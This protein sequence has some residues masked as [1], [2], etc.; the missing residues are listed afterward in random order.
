MLK[1]DDKG[2]FIF[3]ITIIIGDVSIRDIFVLAHM[4]TDM[5]HGLTC[6]MQLEIHTEVTASVH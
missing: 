4:L 3:I 5:V 6:N 1:D 2:Q